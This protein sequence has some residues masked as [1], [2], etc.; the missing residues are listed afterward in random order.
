MSRII[1]GQQDGLQCEKVNMLSLDV[2]EGL[3]VVCGHFDIQYADIIGTRIFRQLSIQ[4]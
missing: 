3:G 2:R 1:D 4:W